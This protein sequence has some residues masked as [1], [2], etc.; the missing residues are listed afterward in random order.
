MKRPDLALI[1]PRYRKW[2]VVE[3]E[4]AHH[5]I[6]THVLPQIDVFCS[7]KYDDGH[8]LYL[9]KQDLSLDLARLTQMMAGL[10]PDVMVV[11]DRPDTSWRRHLRALGALLGIVEPFRGPNDEIMF[12]INGDQPE[13]PGDVL[14]NGAAGLSDAS[15]RLARRPRC[16]LPRVT[17]TCSRSGTRGFQPIG[18][19]TTSPEASCFRS[20][21]GATS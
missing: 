5:D 16:P 1:D 17:M 12:R 18:G 19:D 21:A 2:C 10:P 9:A 13:L 4:L 11:V 8:A 6:Y 20:I 3:V 14:N 15:G 7:G